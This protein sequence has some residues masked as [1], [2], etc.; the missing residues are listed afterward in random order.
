M[1]RGQRP[2][3]T[4]RPPPLPRSSGL[5]LGSR[6]E[7]WGS[8]SP[9]AKVLLRPP[10]NEAH[11]ARIAAQM[12]GN[13][14]CPEAGLV[15]SVLIRAV[16]DD[17]LPIA[18]TV[19]AKGLPPDY[20]TC[21]R[22]AGGDKLTAGTSVRIL[23]TSTAGNIARISPGSPHSWLGGGLRDWTITDEQKLMSVGALGRRGDNILGSRAYPLGSKNNVTGYDG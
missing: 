20:L 10:S 3:G 22:E 17:S 11:S 16:T 12:P 6:S 5:G 14:C 13:A 19:W 8:G 23:A 1:G 7:T 21:E 18:R 15:R 9:G 4:L 2:G